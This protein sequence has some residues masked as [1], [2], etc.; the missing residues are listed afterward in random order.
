MKFKDMKDLS[1]DQYKSVFKNNGLF[2]DEDGKSFPVEMED[3]LSHPNSQEYFQITVQEVIREAI[4]PAL[5]GTNLLDRMQYKPGM[6]VSFGASGAIHAD[7]V[8]EMGEYP[9]I[10]INFGTGSQIITIGKCGLALKF[11]DEWKRYSMFDMLGMYL[12]KMGHALARHKEKKIFSMLTRMGNVT[13]D[14]INPSNSIYGVLTGY[15]IDGTANGAL[16]LDNIYEAYAQLL[17]NGYTPNALLVHPLTFSMFL[18]DPTLRAFAL[19]AGGGTWYNGW[20]GSAQ[21][22][23]PFTTGILGKLGPTGNAYDPATAKPTE[24]LPSATMKLPSHL[25]IPLTVIAS[26]HIPFNAVTKLTDIYMVD[27][28]NIGALIVD[29]EPT[30][31]EIPD[32]LRDITKI[33]IRERYTLAP[34]HNG[35]AIAVLKNVKA[36]PNK[37]ILPVVGQAGTISAITRGTQLLKADGTKA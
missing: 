10:S 4:E 17:A 13:H 8:N 36:V 26:P 23:Y 7:D 12:R 16:N 35:N 34:Y 9:E 21:N 22:N 25:G 15:D 30:M 27:T 19:A 14:N 5:I 37:M 18:T 32:R 11:S 29:E 24:Y 20:N 6:Q 28:N 2:V 33:K 3:A 1:L 31:E